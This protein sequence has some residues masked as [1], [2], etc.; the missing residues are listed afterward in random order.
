MKRDVERTGIFTRRALLLMGGQFAV[1]GMLGARLYQVQVR[2]GARYT[3]LADENRISARMIAPPRGRILDRFG[4]VVAGSSTNW[5]A[6]LV[7]EQADSVPATLD[8]FSALLPLS[9]YERARID[10]DLHRNRKFIPV[11]I[12]EFLTWDE[13]A[14]IEVNAPDLPGIVV[15]A[16]TSRNYP[17]GAKLAHLVGYVAPPNEAD[18]ADDPLL[19]LPGLRIGRAGMEKFHDLGLRGRAGS[20]QLEVNAVGR[21]IRELDR[22]EG[23]PG[24]DV[25]L[26]LDAGL[27]QSV[28][29]T[30]GDESASAVVMD[31]RNGE[32]L[33][34]ATNPS[35]DPSLF[36]AG[37]SQ[38]QWV[39]WTSN[40]RA[41]LINKAVAGLYAPGSTYK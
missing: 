30:L 9:E 12:R 20:V 2:D 31:C 34:M 7:A 6:V 10:R 27:Q 28:L 1:L 15:D 3:T 11:L 40:R 38:A 35:F 29:N 41:P 24:E 14:A 18:V 13:M 19:G 26:T 22:Q 16:G 21:V 25:G 32:V 5:R 33:A 36:N 4:V 8:A 39:E 37:V 17:F 23:V